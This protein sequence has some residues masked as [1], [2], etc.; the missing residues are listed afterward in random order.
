ML[1]A[2]QHLHDPVT[3]TPADARLARESI[4]RLARLP[5]RSRSKTLQVRIQRG[6]EPEQVLSIP[7]SAFGLFKEILAEMAE[8]NAVTLVPAQV[9]LT[10]QQAADLLNVSRPFLIEQLEKKKI[11]HRKVGSHRRIMF[12]DL[13]KYS[14]TMALNRLQALDELSAIDQELG[15]GY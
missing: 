2:T 5:T 4:A 11:P 1:K 12:S 3:P 8:G 13:T 7:A 15:L 10:T 9:E 14:Q 6:N